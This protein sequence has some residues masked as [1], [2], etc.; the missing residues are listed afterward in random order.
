MNIRESRLLVDLG[1]DIRK[2]GKIAFSKVD[3][4]LYL[5]PYSLH[6]KYNYGER[7]VEGINFEDTFN[8]EEG[9]QSDLIPKLSIHATGQ[10]HIKANGNLAG[11][12]YVPPLSE[13]RGQHLATF[14]PDDFSVL[15]KF[16]GKVK[17]TDTK[18]DLAIQVPPNIRSGRFIFYLAGDN[19]SSISPDCNGIFTLHRPGIQLPL[20]IGVK[21]VSQPPIGNPV[22]EGIT[23]LAGWT[24]SPIQGEG[25]DY[26]YIRGT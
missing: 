18:Y 7:S 4:S 9:K 25:T 6:N 23:L 2:V 12:L 10:V 22:G 3:A 11:P 24:P 20:H 26:L 17:H 1:G 15:P 21:A 13:W 5:F 14:C 16:T 8:V 19:N